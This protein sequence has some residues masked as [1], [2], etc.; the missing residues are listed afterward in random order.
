MNK[1]PLNLGGIQI[2]NLTFDEAVARILTLAREHRSQYIVTPNTDHLVRLQEDASFRTV[3]QGAALTVADGMPVIWASKLLGNPLQERI[4][5]ADLLPR[6]CAEAVHHSLSVY[7][8]GAAEGV[9][10]QAAKNLT[11]L[12]PQ[13]KIAG[14]YSPPFGFEHDA[15]ECQRII[16]QINQCSPDIVFVGLGAPKQEFW[17]A[18]YRNSLNTGVLLGI[19]ASI[20]FAAGTEKRA[21][22]VLQKIGL[23]WF[24]RLL[25]DPRRLVLRYLKDFTF[26]LIVYRTWRG[27]YRKQQQ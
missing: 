21:P 4:T 22:L 20:A 23:E 24:Y 8:L 6:L 14:Y 15:A 2:D 18:K 7:F 10:Q 16:D 5:G 26:V 3:Y 9:A 17:I 19:G 1:P 27:K 12:H 25:Q 11:A 13:L